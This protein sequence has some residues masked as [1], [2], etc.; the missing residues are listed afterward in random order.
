VFDPNNVPPVSSQEIVARFILASS[1]IRKS[2]HTVKPDA[3]I[4]FSRVELSVT[5]HRESSEAELW[6]EGVRIASIRETTLH[7]RADVAA[8]VFVDERL[9]S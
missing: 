5:R 9:V 1:H 2:N 6:Q 4:P 3:F 8:Q 7:G